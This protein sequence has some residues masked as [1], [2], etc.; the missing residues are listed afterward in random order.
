M[1]AQLRERLQSRWQ[2]LSVREQRGLRLLGGVVLFALAWQML[3]APAQHKLREAD[4]QRQRIAQQ[5][6]HMLALQAQA[7]ALQQRTAMSREAALKTLQGLSAV[8]GLQLNPQGER[9]V[10]SVKAVS[11][12]ALSDWLAQA[13]T[14]AQSLPG[15]VHLTRS[16]PA[17]NALAATANATDPSTPLWDGSMVLVLP[18]GK[19]TGTP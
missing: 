19:G 3:V 18:R 14:Q 17:A 8:A 13:R 16:T 1:M 10:V 9:V 6:A 5:H 12:A 11:A 7:Q 2:A 15:E 4:A